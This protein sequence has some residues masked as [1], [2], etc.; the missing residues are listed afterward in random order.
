MQAAPTLRLV[1]F[2][3][4]EVNLRTG[5]LRKSGEKIK[6]PE[7]SFQV[8]AMLLAKPGEVIMRPEIQKRLWPNDTIVEFENSINAAVKNLRLALKDSADEPHFIE[9]LARRG[10]RWMVPVQRLEENPLAPAQAAAATSQSISP[11]AAPLIGK[12]VSHYRVLEILGGGGMGVV[13]KAEDI[14]LG[15]RVALKF[16]PDEMASDPAAMERFKREARAASALNHSNICTIYSVE[17]HNGQP[18]IAMELLEGQ[19][20]RELIGLTEGATGT[21]TGKEPLPLGKLLEIAIQISEG[22]DAAH[23]KGIIHRDIKPANVFIT[24]QGRAKILDFGLAKSQEFEGSD[25]GPSHAMEAHSVTNLNLT[26]TGTTIGTAGYM[27]PEQVRGEKV[28][29]RTDLFSFGLVLYEIAVGRRAFSG[30]TAPILQTAILNQTPTPVRQLNPSIP[31]ELET[32]VNKALEKDRAKRYQTAAEIT[33]ALQNLTREAPPRRRILLWLG[34]AAAAV[35]LCVIAFT[36]WPA[37]HHSQ[38]AAELKLTQLTFNSAENPVSDGTISLD[39]TYLAYSDQMGVHVKRIGSDD[40][41]SFLQPDELKGKEIAWEILPQAWFPDSA[42]FLA[43][44]HPQTEELGEW[45]SRTTSVWEFSVSGGVPHKVRD[46]A[47]GFSI[48]P[49]GSMIAFGQNP[50]PKLSYPVRDMASL[51]EREIWVMSPNGENVRSLYDAE[52][53]T[54]LWGLSFLPG[55]QRTAYTISDDTA[56]TLVTRDLAGGP[57]VKLFRPGEGKNLGN[58]AWLPEGRM[59]AADMCDAGNMRPDTP[60]NLWITR[61]DTTTGKLLEKPRQITN[62]VGQG[63]DLPSATSD[64]KRVTILRYFHRT[65]SYL[66][67]LDA[68]ARLLNPKPFMPDEGNFD[69]VVDWTPDGKAILLNSNRG[70]YTTFQ[71]LSLNTG[72]KETIATVPGLEVY[73]FLSPDG[74]WIIAQITASSDQPQKLVR[75]PIGGGTSEL[76]FTLAIFNSFACARSPSNLCAVAEQTPDHK[77]AVITSFDPIKGRGK[78]L[79]RFDLGA[80]YQARRFGVNWAMSDDGTKIAFASDREGPIYVR[81][82]RTGQ[83][84]VIHARGLNEIGIGGLAWKHDGKGFWVGGKTKDG[85][86]VFYVDLQGDVKMLWNC[87]NGGFCRGKASPNGHQFKI[88]EFKMIYNLWMIENF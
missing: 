69:I 32:I 9:T 60:C 82:L 53:Q 63:M 57:I 54:G 50:S 51:G 19:T 26:R 58:P 8:L 44:A 55:S 42:R 2:E 10:Y 64:G 39:G 45:S 72:A 4:F 22:L 17:E 83:Q 78:E 85:N 24:S 35:T 29:S 67:D 87:G 11:V 37:N 7:Q 33:A 14:K 25:L 13:Y 16:L 73:A 56:D 47:V 71:K 20:L 65:T 43:N 68:G 52:E 1:R 70:D 59:I 77:H 23:Q 48:S 41:V 12:K 21:A 38:P 80:E 31:L 76:I 27:S 61:F 5:E 84:Q 79:T 81:S 88:D 18:F 36:F 15:R 28:D 62:W 74:K 86:G 40:A 30:E 75:I 6:L 49:D 66:S 3:S 34:A 46:N